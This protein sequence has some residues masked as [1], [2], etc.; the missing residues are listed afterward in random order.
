M[1]YHS[2]RISDGN[3]PPMQFRANLRNVISAPVPASPR[4][5][6]RPRPVPQTACPSCPKFIPPSPP[7][8]PPPQQM[9]PSSH[10]QEK[11]KK[12]HGNKDK[13]GKVSAQI[14]AGSQGNGAERDRRRTPFLRFRTN[15]YCSRD[16]MTAYEG[17]ITVFH[18][19]LG[20]QSSAIP[21]ICDLFC[22][23]NFQVSHRPARKGH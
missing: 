22:L 20:R 13:S 11:K 12:I 8:P 14:T 1:I 7:P 3:F 6:P 15:G 5:A 19:V 16:S 4:L 23:V 17:V 2:A 10:L 9:R 18:P 21:C